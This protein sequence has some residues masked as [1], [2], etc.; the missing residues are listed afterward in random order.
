MRL[1]PVRYRAQHPLVLCPHWPLHQPAAAS[2]APVGHGVRGGQCPPYNRRTAPTP[3]R[4][5]GT[6][7]GFCV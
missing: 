4:R 1:Q 5:A 3:E 2:L 6:A 7:A